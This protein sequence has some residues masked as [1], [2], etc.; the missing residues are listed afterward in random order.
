MTTETVRKQRQER[1]AQQRRKKVH[2]RAKRVLRNLNEP[3]RLLRKCSPCGEVFM[4]DERVC[5][6]CS[7]P[8]TH[9]VDDEARP[10]PP[11]VAP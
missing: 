5:P 2:G 8:F 1:K 3:E 7:S 6:Q 11:W 4:S 10:A 9:R